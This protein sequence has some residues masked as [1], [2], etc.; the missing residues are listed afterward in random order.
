MLS[1]YDI[2]CSDSIQKNGQ[3]HEEGSKDIQLDYGTD[4]GVLDRFV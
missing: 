2:K 3:R 4:I 1:G